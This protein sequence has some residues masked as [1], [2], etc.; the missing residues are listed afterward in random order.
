MTSQTWLTAADTNQPVWMHWLMVCI[1]D[2]VR[3]YYIN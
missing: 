1:P 2:E 3:I